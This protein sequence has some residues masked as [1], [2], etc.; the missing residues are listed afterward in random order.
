MKY[1]QFVHPSSSDLVRHPVPISRD[2]REGKQGHR[3]QVVWLTGLPGS[4]KSTIAYAF[5]RHLSSEGIASVVLD[6]DAL[7]LGLC[8][9]LGFSFEDRNENVRRAAEVAKL[10]LDRGMVVIVALV[11]P[12]QEAREQARRTV[13][14]SDFLEVFCSC[15][16]AVCQQRDPKGHYAK[17]KAGSMKEFTGVSSP[18]EAPLAPDII[19]DTETESVDT[20]VKRLGGLVL[21]R[22][23][24]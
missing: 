12:L 7:R 18:Y 2:Q 21:E 11:S 16:L 22:I 3:G 10:F 24:C 6:G 19:L 20:C 14:T 15:R 1:D 4:G 9:D 23:R 17:A 5:D 13:S 8:S